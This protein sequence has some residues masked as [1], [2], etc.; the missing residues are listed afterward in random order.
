M[1]LCY[2]NP[3]RT[4]PILFLAL[5]LALP[6]TGQAGSPDQREQL[7]TKPGSYRTELALGSGY[8]W[9]SL[10]RTEQDLTG[11]PAFVRI[12]FNMNPLFDIEG[13]SSSLQC[14]VEPFVNTTLTPQTGAESGCGLGLRYLHTL[15]RP[16]EIY[17]EASIAPMYFSID[18]LEQGHSGF[19]FLMHIGAGLQYRVSPDM[20]IFTGYRFRHLSH[21][22]IADR[23]NVGIESSA[24]VAGV[25]WYY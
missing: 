19:N 18:T 21:G 10:K 7:N 25:A 16:I 8:M 22:N 12:G 1:P 9:G 3:H 24:I 11:I 13:N 20:G 4:I 17:T 2:N 15:T 6:V 14:T 5:L 23:P